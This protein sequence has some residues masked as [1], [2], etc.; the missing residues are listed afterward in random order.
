M[1]RDMHTS[2]FVYGRRMKQIRVTNP[3]TLTDGKEI[4]I[5]F[6]WEELVT[7]KLFISFKTGPII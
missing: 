4:L 6:F 1:A 7:F 2:R 3:S 5:F